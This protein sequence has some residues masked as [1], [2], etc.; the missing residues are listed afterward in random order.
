L[1]RRKLA[2]FAEMDQM[3][4]VFAYPEDKAGQWHQFF[5]NNNPLVIE[6]GCGTGRYTIGLARMFPDK[7]FI[8][9]DIKG[10]RMWH[11]AKAIE[12]EG[13]TNAAFLRTQME[14][15][16]AYFAP[17]EVAEIWITFPDPQPRESRERKRLTSPRFLELYKPFLKNEGI[18]HLKTDNQVLFDYS[19][20]AWRAYGLQPDMVTRDLYAAPLADPVLEIKTTYEERYLALGL[21]I[22]YMRAVVSGK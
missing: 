6:V 11:G 17:G 1:A 4:Y 8:G 16:Q 15:I 14:S 18:I 10:S 13:L 5:G 21:P 12:A 20:E 3:P 22:C 2:H 7:N 19:E 9:L